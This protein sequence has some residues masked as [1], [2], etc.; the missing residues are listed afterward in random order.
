M[1]ISKACFVI[2]GGADGIGRATAQL[3]LAR[4]AR[5]VLGDVDPQALEACAE[6]LAMVSD[7]G[8]AAAA[9]PATSAAEASDTWAPVQDRVRTV[10]ADVRTLADHEKLANAATEAFGGFDVW[11]NNAGVA[12]H[13]RIV[14][15]DEE[16]IDWMLDVNLKGTILGSQ[17]ALRQLAARGGD[18]DSAAGHII[19]IVSTAGLRGIPTESVYCST[20]WAVRGFTQALVEEAAQHGVR[21]TALLPGGVATAFWDDARESAVGTSH[22]LDVDDVARAILAALEMPDACCVRE[23]QLRSMRDYDFGG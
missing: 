18:V 17:V 14:D 4:G 20:K 11:I 19:N 13:R 6:S 16:Q 21:A 3:A 12:R 10:V 1:D 8:V 7:I 22:M 23:L 15:Y 5:C 2:T 9:E